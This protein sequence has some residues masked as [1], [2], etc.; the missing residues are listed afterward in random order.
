MA[1]REYQFGR[2]D[3]LHRLSRDILGRRLQLDLQLL[4]V[5]EEGGT[6][7][8]EWFRVV[9]ARI[10]LAGL[11]DQLV[12]GQRCLAVVCDQ[13]LVLQLIRRVVVN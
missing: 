6:Q 7:P 5:V 9:A 12:K 2:V 13:L 3:V 1:Q 4:E 10:V 11:S 8:L